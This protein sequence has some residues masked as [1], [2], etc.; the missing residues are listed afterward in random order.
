MT[1][2]ELFFKEFLES[3]LQSGTLYLVL[4]SFFIPSIFMVFVREMDRRT[5]FSSFSLSNDLSVF[6]G[7]VNYWRLLEVG[8]GEL[9]VC[10]NVEMGGLGI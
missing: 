9:G 6:R 3:N 10:C 8:L 5:I 2:L 7:F 1:M 4:R